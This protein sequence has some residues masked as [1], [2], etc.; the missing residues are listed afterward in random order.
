M[1]GQ[2]FLIFLFAILNI[3]IAIT[4]GQSTTT[5]A[6]TTTVNVTFPGIMNDMDLTEELYNELM[7][8]VDYHDVDEDVHMDNVYK[9]DDLWR[10]KDGIIPYE[11]H[12]NKT[13][14]QDFK[15]RIETVIKNINLNLSDCIHIR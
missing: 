3:H 8:N 14:H 15:D 13:F 11:F 4:N 2:I 10:W 12:Q 5:V 7:G 9:K 6:T 1:P